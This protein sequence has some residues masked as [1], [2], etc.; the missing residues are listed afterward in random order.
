MGWACGTYGER[1]C[2]FKVIVGK[3]GS[4]RSLE[5]PR[6]RWLYDRRIIFKWIHRN[7]EGGA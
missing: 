4:N 3:P 6:H 5:R 1:K 7:Q 2:T